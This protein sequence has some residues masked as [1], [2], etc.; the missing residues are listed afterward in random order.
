M[1]IYGYVSR[2][3]KPFSPSVFDHLQYTNTEMER[4]G[5]LAMSGDVGR[6]KANTRQALRHRGLVDGKWEIFCWAPPLCIL[7]LST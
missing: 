6:Q 7:L 3:P 4:L 2:I 1:Y 5:D